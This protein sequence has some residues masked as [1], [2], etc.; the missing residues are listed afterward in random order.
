MIDAIDR[1][2][3][4]ARQLRARG[5]AAGACDAFAQAADLARTNG[6]PR[7]AYALRH[8]SDLQREANLLTESHAS[9]DEA[10]AVLRAAGP[11]LD[12][13]NALRLRALAAEALGLDLAAADWAEAGRLYRELGVAEGVAECEARS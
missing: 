10:V 3:D 5:D 7:L 9:A 11:A 12:L 4:E 2:L 8:L 1:Q 13:A 6:D